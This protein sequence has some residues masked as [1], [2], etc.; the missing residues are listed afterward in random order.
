MSR[1]KK[2]KTKIQNIPYES[3]D[4]KGRY[5]VSNSKIKI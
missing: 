1:L 4:Q 5:H 3:K 2:L